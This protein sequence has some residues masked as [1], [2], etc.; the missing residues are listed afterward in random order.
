[1]FRGE[2]TREEGERLVAA[3][4]R[5]IDAV[6]FRRVEGKSAKGKWWVRV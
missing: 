5:D 3:L 6:D 1:L 4:R 2:V